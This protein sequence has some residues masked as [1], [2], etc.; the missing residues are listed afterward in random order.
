MPITMPIVRLFG[1]ALLDPLN[2]HCNDLMMGIVIFLFR[3][4]P[5]SFR[6]G[7]EFRGIEALDRADSAGI[8]T[9]A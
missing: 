7:D 9:C 4:D 6:M 5:V 8:F 1:W 3:P 2:R